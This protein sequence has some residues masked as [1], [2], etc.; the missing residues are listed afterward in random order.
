MV[1]LPKGD[2]SQ[3]SVENLTRAILRFLFRVVGI[4]H[5]HLV[6]TRTTD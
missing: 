3:D 5:M 6:N 4:G 1:L 2:L